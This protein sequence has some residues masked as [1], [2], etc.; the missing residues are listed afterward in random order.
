MG[1]NENGKAPPQPPPKPKQ[2]PIR[3][4][5]EPAQNNMMPP[6]GPSRGNNADQPPSDISAPPLQTGSTQVSVKLSTLMD[7]YINTMQRLERKLHFC[8]IG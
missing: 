8:I 7:F 5:A 1:R 3:H 2:K 4:R 6:P